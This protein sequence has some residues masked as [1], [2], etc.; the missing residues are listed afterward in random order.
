MPAPA[1]IPL[2]AFRRG[3]MPLSPNAPSRAP[4][5]RRASMRFAAT[6]R[7]R[8]RLLPPREPVTGRAFSAPL[9]RLTALALPTAPATLRAATPSSTGLRARSDRLPTDGIIAVR[10]PASPTS[11]F[12]CVADCDHTFANASTLPTV[13]QSPPPPALPAATRPS[14]PA[15]RRRRQP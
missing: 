10:Y 14:L 3:L 8:D 9:T 11:S 15:R 4:G 12:L 5:G 2:I 7:L 13:S 1:R 6:N